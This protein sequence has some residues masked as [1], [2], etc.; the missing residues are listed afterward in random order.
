MEAAQTAKKQPEF[1]A[2]YQAMGRRRGKKIATTAVARKLLTRAYHLLQD[3]ADTSA[4]TR[5]STRKKKTPPAARA[6]RAGARRAS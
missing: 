3:A 4:P 5:A 1:A 2:S 6:A